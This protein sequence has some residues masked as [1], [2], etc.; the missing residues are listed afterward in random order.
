MAAA[1]PLTAKYGEQE[2]SGFVDD[3]AGNSAPYVYANWANAR[4]ARAQL[5]GGTAPLNF[6]KW[7][8]HAF[9]APGLGGPEVSVLPAG[10]FQN[11][12][13]AVQNQYGTSISYV[14]DTQQY[15]LTFI[16]VSPSDPA[17]GP[18][19]GGRLGAAWFWS[20][21][22]TLS[23]ETQW[24]TPQEIAGSWSEFDSSGGCPD[25]KGFY[26]SFMS[27]GKSAGHLSLAGYV[28]YLWGCQGAGTHGGRQFSSR[29]FTIATAAA[30]TLTSGSLAN[31]ATYISGGLVPGSWAQV[32]GSGLSPVTRLWGAADFAGLGD[33]LPTNLSGVQV[34]VNNLPAAVYYID[35]GQVNFPGPSVISGT[36]SVQVINN[37]VASN[38]ITA[39][40]AAVSPGIFPII[41]GGVNYAAAVFL[42]GKIAGDPANGSAFRKAKPGDIVQLYATGL[43]PT[44]AGVL[45]VPQGVSGVTVK[46]GDTS[47]PADF[48]GLVAVG[49]FQ[50][51][52]RV[53]APL[54]DGTYP[55][56]IAVNGVSSPAAINSNP[57]GPVV[58]P[59]QN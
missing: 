6:Q 9:A 37:G 22:Y 54:A 10:S 41:I 13:A 51:N 5:N 43:A 38:A 19:G 25:Y 33:N 18:S 21:S 31:A 46:V 16:C 32:K 44:P 3:V 50:I 12:G 58:L 26:P 2:I 7:D 23:D 20:S 1:K 45:P 4:M 47:V 49:E 53:P 34:N 42:D 36:A 29:A 24:S 15:L 28:F 30:P 56:S 35:S 17:L 39:P 11:C 59:V 8:G 55:I 57:P 40:A 14:D 27:P 48:A 52:F